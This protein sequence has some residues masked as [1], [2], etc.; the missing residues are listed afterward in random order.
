M[1]THTHKHMCLGM[2]LLSLPPWEKSRAEGISLEQSSFR[3]KRGNVGRIKLYFI[4]FP[5]VFSPVLHQSLVTFHLGAGT[6][7][8]VYSYI[9]GGHLGVC[10]GG[11]ALP[12]IL[13]SYYHKPHFSAFISSEARA[14]YVSLFLS[15]RQVRQWHRQRPCVLYKT[16]SGG[17]FIGSSSQ[18]KS[19]ALIK[20]G[21]V[22][23]N[24]RWGF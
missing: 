18:A 10:M 23:T 1:S 17:L 4:S 15:Q 14:P 12:L 6:L 7:T 16:C 2:G 13:S 20:S 24:Q 3:L 22:E 11:G 19:S 8:K 5:S 21:Q 9:N